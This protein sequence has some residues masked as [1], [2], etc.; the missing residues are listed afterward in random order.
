MEMSSLFKDVASIIAEKCIN[1]K[2]Q[3]PYTITMIERALRDCHFSVDPKRSAKQ[4]ALQA[5]SQASSLSPTLYKHFKI[6]I[7]RPAD[8]RFLIGAKRDV[9]EQS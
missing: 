9:E 2:T 4:Q 6:T 7:Q 5:T 3:R 1:P 8:F